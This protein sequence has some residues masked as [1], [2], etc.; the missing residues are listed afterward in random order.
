MALASCITDSN[1]AIGRKV[2]STKAKPGSTLTVLVKLKAAKQ[3]ALEGLA[4]A[5]VFPE[6]YVSATGRTSALPK[7]GILM[8][9][10]NNPASVV[11][12]QFNLNAGQR[13]YFK[14]KFR[15]AHSTPAGAE[16][17]FEVVAF[18]TSVANGPYCPLTTNPAKVKVFGGRH[19]RR[20][21]A[22]VA[23]ANTTSA[24]NAETE[25][26]SRRLTAVGPTPS[27]NLRMK[28]SLSMKKGARAR[29]D[30]GSNVV[31]V[32]A[33]KANRHVHNGVVGILLPAGFQVLQ[34][35]STF[36]RRNPAIISG[37]V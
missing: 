16:L 34:A 35:S 12:P 24:F 2:S 26:E 13:R 33:V 15:V 7:A 30:A 18:Q 9:V 32:A 27:C 28:T 17:E 29:K 14:S 1:L 37:Q 36:K 4:L 20:A 31:I 3:A 22:T 25:F 19:A 10:K 11:W 21:H 5:I 6:S 8:P 23:D